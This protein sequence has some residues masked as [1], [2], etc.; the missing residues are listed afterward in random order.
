MSKRRNKSRLTKTD[1]NTICEM[2]RKIDAYEEY[3]IGLCELIHHRGE[4]QYA[5]LLRDTDMDSAV[6]HAW[7]EYKKQMKGK[8]TFDGLCNGD[9]TEKKKQRV[10]NLAEQICELCDN[11]E[12]TTLDKVDAL[13]IVMNH[14]LGRLKDVARHG[15]AD[16]VIRM[17][18][19]E[20]NK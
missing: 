15:V 17:L 11:E 10:A 19:S 3:I 18:K 2:Q 4:T 14:M 7:N 12:V 20:L 5:V 8:E 13:T 6:N 9:M 1:V 16:G